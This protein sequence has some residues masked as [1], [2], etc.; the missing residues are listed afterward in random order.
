M[1]KNVMCNN[2]VLNSDYEF[3]ELD[4]SNECKYCRN[5][6]KKSFKGLDRLYE[7]VNLFPEEKLGITVSGGKD[8]IY[9]WGK[10]TE[11]FGSDKIVAFSYYRE[12]LTHPLAL[13]NIMNT[14]KI[15]G[16][17]LVII[18]DNDALDRFKKNF[19]VLLKQP[20]AAM[21]RVLL[22]TGCRYGITE[23]LYREGKKQGIKKYIS[24][25]SY[26]ELAPFKEE[27]LQ[28]NSSD[29]NIDIGLENAL[30]N[31]PL[32][33]EDVLSLIWRDQRYK[34]KNNHTLGNNIKTDEY[35]YTLFD[36]DDYAENNPEEIEKQV[37]KKYGWQRPERSWHFDCII[38]EFKDV[39]YYGLLGYTELDFKLSAMVRYNLITR[40]EAQ[41][42]IQI[43][44]ENLKNSYER[45]KAMLIE[46]KMEDNIEDLKSFYKSSKYL[47]YEEE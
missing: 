2:C 3:I 24:G 42:R 25:A 30:K 10:L 46:M 17:E 28:S 18:K 21:V 1:C 44:N 20:D 33:G 13:E 27:L 38:E 14:K 35:E 36:F 45:I 41:K 40:N 8:S 9:M 34:Y 12:G 43:S 7:D 37:V 32:L 11:V 47:K 23:N 39:M 31:Y 22:C 19:S 6:I 4:S 16:T 29:G 26:L 5:F 15:L